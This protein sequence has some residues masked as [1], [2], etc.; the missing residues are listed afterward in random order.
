[1]YRPWNRLFKRMQHLTKILFA[2]FYW[3]RKKLKFKN[4]DVEIADFKIF[5]R[6]SGRYKSLKVD[7]WADGSCHKRVSV[8]ERTGSQDV[9]RTDYNIEK[10]IKYCSKQGFP[11]VALKEDTSVAGKTILFCQN[12]R[13]GLILLAFSP[14]KIVWSSRQRK[15]AKVTLC[16]KL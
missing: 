3:S 9:D 10:G 11:Y 13:L 4:G 1:M 12:T 6:K 2:G 16:M 5:Y 7:E 8:N 14:S 15:K